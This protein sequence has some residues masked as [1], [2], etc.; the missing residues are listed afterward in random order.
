MAGVAGK[1]GGARPGAGRK[2]G[3][4]Q[5]LKAD[6]DDPVVFLRQV[7][8]EKGADGRLRVR[9]AIELAK[10]EGNMEPGVGSKKSRQ[11]AAAA[12]AGRGKL[13]PGAPPRLAVD[14]TR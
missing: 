4:I 6:S 7:M 5:L 11:T 10:L 2:P 14:N 12:D 9:A 13:A 8:Q 3:P 1:S